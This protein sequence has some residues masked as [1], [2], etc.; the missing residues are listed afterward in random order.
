M[1]RALRRRLP[2]LL[3][4]H[5]DVAL[6]PLSGEVATAFADVELSTQ[7]VAEAEERA[8]VAESAL[9]ASQHRV[10]ALETQVAV[11][12]PAP[13][14]CSAVAAAPGWPPPTA[15]GALAA[16]AAA[17]ARQDLRNFLRVPATAN[18]RRS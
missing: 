5:L 3:A 16:Q 12:K 11:R 4:E 8:R 6:A 18:F 13:S 14:A 1:D 10:S 2:A 15:P 7:R 9:A 17:G